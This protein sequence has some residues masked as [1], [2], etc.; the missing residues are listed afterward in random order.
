MD[1]RQHRAAILARPNLYQHICPIRVRQ[2]LSAFRTPKKILAASLKEL[3]QVEDIKAS[4]ALAI[5]ELDSWD[6][7]NREIAK[8][9]EL[10][11]RGVTFDRSAY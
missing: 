1:N 2:L 11:V 3:L 7:I 6:L 10:D 9:E 5:D 4:S 8:F